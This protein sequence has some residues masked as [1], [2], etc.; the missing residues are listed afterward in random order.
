MF[1]PHISWFELNVLLNL[2]RD[3][4]LFPIFEYMRNDNDRLMKQWYGYNAFDVWDRIIEPLFLVSS[5]SYLTPRR[6]Y[7]D[8]IAF[9]KSKPILTEFELLKERITNEPF[10]IPPDT[11][12]FLKT[13]KQ[14]L[15]K[16]GYIKNKPSNPSIA[17]FYYYAT[18]C[19]ELNEARINETAWWIN[20][21]Q[22]RDN[23]VGFTFT[24]RAYQ[25]HGQA[26]KRTTRLLAYYKKHIE[27]A[28]S[29]LKASKVE[30]PKAIKMANEELLLHERK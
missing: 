1:D 20:E 11:E 8:I 30:F 5:N 16:V 9:I 25:C 17:L 27:K 15:S 3:K 19:G 7:T 2:L 29:L 23:A 21:G 22:T 12:E 6:D 28:I 14:L 10:S 4:G 24:R 26:C 18:E 13:C